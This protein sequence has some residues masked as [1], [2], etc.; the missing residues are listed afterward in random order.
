MALKGRE[1][2]MVIFAGIAIAVLIFDR[3][4]I[5]PQSQ[6]ISQWK[7]DVKAADQKIR[8]FILLT[9]GIE[10]VEAEVARLEKELKGLSD[11]TLKGEEFRA[12]LRHL[13]RAS[14]TLQMKIVSLNPEEE[15][16]SPPEGKKESPTLQYKKVTIQ[17]V[18]HSTYH[19]LG[20][21]LRDVE[22]LPF[23]LHVDSLQIERS[24]ES[25]PLLKV[26]MGLSMHIVSL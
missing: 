20:I 2:L 23:L 22:K 24:E 25:L 4:Y 10:T 26:T 6:K 19:K 16:L 3:A 12:F 9:T 18:V 13:A 11:R 1:K 17:M 15:K 7:E 14:E 8:E 5:T 21:Y